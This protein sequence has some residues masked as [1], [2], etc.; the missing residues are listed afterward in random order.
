MRIELKRENDR[1]GRGVQGGRGDGAAVRGIDVG[2]WVGE[3][4]EDIQ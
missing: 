2:V 3:V 4:V 1:M